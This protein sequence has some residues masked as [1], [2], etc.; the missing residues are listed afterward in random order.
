MFKQIQ[1]N[2]SLEYDLKMI[3]LGLNIIAM[4]DTN[5]INTN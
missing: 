5:L 3:E 2:K 1:D 4:S